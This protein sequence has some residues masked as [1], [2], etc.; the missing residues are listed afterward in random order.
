M[1]FFAYPKHGDSKMWCYLYEL[2]FASTAVYGGDGADYEL[3]RGEIAVENAD[4]FDFNTFAEENAPEIPGK[5]LNE[6]NM[7]WD[8]LQMAE[9][10]G[11]SGMAF[12]QIVN[13]Y[14]NGYW[15][16]SYEEIAGY[17]MRHHWSFNYE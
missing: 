10:Y 14:E 17:A 15:V 12:R 8:L 16:D 4:E 13:E 5:I 6:F 11:N 3:A 7:D 1:G 2:I 9:Q